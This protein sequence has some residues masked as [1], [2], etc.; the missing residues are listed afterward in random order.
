MEP[1]EFLTTVLYGAVLGAL[2]GVF[3]YAT[4]R[5]QGE[6]FDPR[7]LG[8]T[9]FVWGIAGAIVA[10]SPREVGEG[11]I[12]EQ[13]AAIGGLGIIFDQLWIYYEKNYAAE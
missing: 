11:T 12:Q 4:G 6:Q 9:V 5:D 10:A 1:V 13:A 8:R 2:Y 7:R 3:N